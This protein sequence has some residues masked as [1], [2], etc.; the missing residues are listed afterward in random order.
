[1]MSDELNR[2]H[3]V[4][5]DLKSG[6]KIGAH[7]SKAAVRYSLCFT[8][9]GAVTLLLERKVV[10]SRGEAVALMQKMMNADYVGHMTNKKKFKDEEHEFY[11]CAKA[12]PLYGCVKEGLVSCAFSDTEYFSMFAQLDEQGLRL[13]RA[14]EHATLTYPLCFVSVDSIV[15]VAQKWEKKEVVLFESVCFVCLF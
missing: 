1:M 9:E 5:F 6:I 13:F 12:P 11:R 10:S 15:R 2:V 7:T 8:G 4:L 14:R 3:A